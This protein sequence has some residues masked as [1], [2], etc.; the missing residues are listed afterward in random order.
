MTLASDRST[1][2]PLI[3]AMDVFVLPQYFAAWG[4]PPWLESP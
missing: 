4:Y 2:S 1:T 3:S